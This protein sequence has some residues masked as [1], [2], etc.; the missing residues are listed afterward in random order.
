MEPQKVITA[1]LVIEGT[2]LMFECGGTTAD[3]LTVPYIYVYTY[4][5]PIFLSD[6]YLFNHGR[7]VK[8]VLAVFIINSHL[9]RTFCENLDQRFSHNSTLCFYLELFSIVYSEYEICFKALIVT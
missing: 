5:G 4:T 6:Y 2:Q 7:I 8:S 9:N 1:V 3:Y